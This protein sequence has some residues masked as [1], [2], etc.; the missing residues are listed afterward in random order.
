MKNENQIILRDLEIFEVMVSEMDGYLMSEAT[1]WTMEKGDMPKLTIG[2]CLMR[3]QRLPF[4][5]EQLDDAAQKRLEIARQ[6]FEALLFKN[7]VRFETRMHQE[8]HARLSE[9]SSYLGHLSS[10]MMADVNY[11]A[12]V[13]DVRVVISAMIE[14]LQKPVYQLDKQIL[15]E[16]TALDQNLKGRWQVGTF[17]WPAVWQDAYP[18]EKFW[19]LYGRPQ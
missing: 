8:L 18:P 7:V 6:S 16:I 4:V 5:G 14:E 9:W 3:R 10:R 11:Y 13:S 1:H 12:D 2:G 19:W 17:V 15:E